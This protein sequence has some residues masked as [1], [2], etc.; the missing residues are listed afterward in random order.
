MSIGSGA[1]PEGGNH[2]GQG[3]LGKGEQRRLCSGGKKK[4]K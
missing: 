3:G 4:E 1:W 2:E